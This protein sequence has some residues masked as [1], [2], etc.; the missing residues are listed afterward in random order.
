MPT[1]N[2]EAIET[3]YVTSE[4]SQADLVKKHGVSERQVAWHASRGGWVKKR[5]EW[6]SKTA[7][8]AQENAG[9]LLAATLGEVIAICHLH[10][11][12]Y[13]VELEGGGDTDEPTVR[14]WTKIFLQDVAS[15]ERLRPAVQQHVVDVRQM[16]DAELDRILG[17]EE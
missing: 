5:E 13:R 10:V 11:K 8:K 4:V 14:A 2:W 9:D 16:A 1:T 12:R 17:D 3:E 7:V 15:L 6:R